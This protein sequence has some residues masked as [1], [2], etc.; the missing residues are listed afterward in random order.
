VV[1]R[2]RLRI[3]SD[4]VLL[5]RAFIMEE[6]IAL[7]LD[8]TFRLGPELEPYARRE[9]LAQLSPAALARRLEQVGVEL[10]QLTIE[11]PSRLRRVLDGVAGGSGLEIHLPPAE[12][13][14]L[15]ANARR[16]GNRITASM[17]AAAVLNAI[18]LRTAGGQPHRR[19]RPNPVMRTVVLTAGAAL[20]AYVG[21]K[22][23]SDLAGVLA[24]VRGASNASPQVPAVMDPV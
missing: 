6:S 10:G 18:A 21:W 12:I 15:V 19:H 7:E 8:P 17:L 23:R 20:S 11:A 9:V 13:E 16:L 3:P 5:L 1:R 2:H 22:A 24:R 14:P 4:L